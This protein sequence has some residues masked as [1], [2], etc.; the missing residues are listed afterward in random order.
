M[1]NVW[2]LINERFNK[3]ISVETHII[4]VNVVYLSVLLLPTT[5]TVRTASDTFEIT[6]VAKCYTGCD[7]LVA[8]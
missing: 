7:K 8:V 2:C 5:A 6:S 1:H 4:N 3:I